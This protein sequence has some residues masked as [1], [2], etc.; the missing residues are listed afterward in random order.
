MIGCVL[1]SLTAISK[2]VWWGFERNSSVQI[3]TNI[4]NILNEQEIAKHL[5]REEKVKAYR[6]REKQLRRERRASDEVNTKFV[7]FK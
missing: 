2:Y 1:K 5:Q 6:R 7:I 3:L 4:A